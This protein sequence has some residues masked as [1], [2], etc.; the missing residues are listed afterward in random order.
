M[1]SENGGMLSV[2]ATLPDTP[3]SNPRHR[4]QTSHAASCTGCMRPRLKRTES[5]RFVTLRH[6]VKLAMRIGGG[7]SASFSSESEPHHIAQSQT[8]NFLPARPKKEL[9][10]RNISIVCGELYSNPVHLYPACEPNDPML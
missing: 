10:R 5:S 8:L 2:P 6:V 4:S 1:V 9:A 7:T 3:R